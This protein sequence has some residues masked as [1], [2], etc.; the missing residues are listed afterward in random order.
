[1]IG[2]KYDNAL[3]EQELAWKVDWVILGEMGNDRCD[4]LF[5]AHREQLE[6]LVR[7]DLISKD[8]QAVH[9]GLSTAIQFQLAKSL[10]FDQ[11]VTAFRNSKDDLGAEVLA[12]LNDPRA[13]PVLISAVPD[14]PT[15]YS[16]DLCILLMNRPAHPSVPRLLQS[17]DPAVR[18]EAASVL[19]S[20]KDPALAPAV[21]AL[22]RDKSS[23]V[24]SCA[25]ELAVQL[26]DV[27][28]QQVR[29]TLLELLSDFDT[30]VRHQT[31]VAMAGRADV[32]GVRRL[33]ELLRQ[34][35]KL[36]GWQQSDLFHTIHAL[37]GS[38]PGL[39]RGMP[40]SPADHRQAIQRL[41]R[42]L[43]DHPAPQH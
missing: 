23:S 26:P 35:E 17:T 28:Y 21:L 5:H 19:S 12:E 3:S 29:P 31:A 14:Q 10:D 20:A 27:A 18:G 39:E 33:L 38:Y 7:E 6:S 42:W 8:S 13:I 2:L 32:A 9:R 16:R 43:V 37:F 25:A 1:V 24:R 22:A 30:Q 40:P 15:H 4:G 11:V 34:R 36:D 41:E